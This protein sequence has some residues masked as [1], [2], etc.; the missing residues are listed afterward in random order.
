MV[1]L[2]RGY[3]SAYLHVFNAVALY[4][5][6]CLDVYAISV[7]HDLHALL[8]SFFRSQMPFPPFWEKGL[9]PQPFKTGGMQIFVCDS[10]C[11]FCR[12]SF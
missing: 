7:L 11:I 9:P 1:S 6:T 8:C 2:T 10:A 3:V 5:A 4:L 12:F